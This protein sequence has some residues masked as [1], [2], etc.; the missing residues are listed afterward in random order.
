MRCAD[1]GN[2]GARAQATDGRALSPAQCCGKRQLARKRVIHPPPMQ[3]THDSGN[4]AIQ[5]RLDIVNDTRLL[6]KRSR[7]DFFHGETDQQR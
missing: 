1:F 6:H 2:A 5:D 7:A 4:D 3:P